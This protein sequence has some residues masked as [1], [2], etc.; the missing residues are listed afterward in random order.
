MIDSISGS[1]GNL[2]EY[3]RGVLKGGLW[4]PENTR[5]FASFFGQERYWDSV[6][7][8]T[9]SLRDDLSIHV[10]YPYVDRVYR[11]SYYSYFSSKLTEVPRNC[12][13]VC[14]FNPGMDDNSFATPEGRRWLAQNYL[15]FFVIRPT[16]GANIG[17]SCIS[18][19]AFKRHDFEICVTR[20][21]TWIRG[22]KLTCEGFPY[23]SQDA[24]TM[25]C[26]ETSL[27]ALVEYFSH[28]YQNYTPV[29][30]S[31]IHR[32]LADS[33]VE[34]QVPSNGLSIPTLSYGLKALGFA[35]RIYA[36][37]VFEPT[38][39]LDLLDIYMESGI[40]VLTGMSN[41]TV[42]HA[43]L[44]IGKESGSNYPKGTRIG[45]VNGHGIYDYPNARKLIVID[46]NHPPYTCLD[47]DAND[48]HY[49]AINAKNWKG[50]KIDSVIVPLYPKVYLEAFEARAYMVNQIVGSDVF[51]GLDSAVTVRVFLASGRSYKKYA[52]ED[53]EMDPRL[54]LV[55]A[56]IETSKLIWVAEV[57]RCN[58][59]GSLSPDHMNVEGLMIVD[60]TDPRRLPISRII[61]A[62]GNVLSIRS[63]DSMLKTFV[64]LR[65]FKPFRNLRPFHSTKPNSNS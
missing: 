43:F 44:T 15:G 60:A 35:T 53:A 42:G 13:R 46:D 21:D 11:D 18:P 27:W 59:N 63:Q 62:W 29:L 34:R 58:P 5:L 38:V 10:E 1:I 19:L 26:A 39:L 3:C 16:P 64:P 57:Y 17:R 2:E 9:A 40:P 37:Q 20:I 47:R 51:D 55:V 8:L 61:G 45:E 54:S 32:V 31:Q 12:I 56:S 48:A 22:L 14:L 30:P 41:G 25:T 50:C 33:M 6:G 52:L 4:A 36:T 65:P 24:E 49:M 28:R 7:D 23:S